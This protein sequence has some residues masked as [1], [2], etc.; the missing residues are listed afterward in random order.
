[1][2]ILPAAVMRLLACFPPLFSSR[3]WRHVPLLVLGALLAPGPRTVT[4]VWRGMGVDQLA[5]VQT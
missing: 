5:T 4:A 2:P 3:V 1:M